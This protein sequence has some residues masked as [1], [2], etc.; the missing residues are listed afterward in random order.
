ML[1]NIGGALANALI[2]LAGCLPN[3]TVDADLGVLRAGLSEFDRGGTKDCA[4][5]TCPA[6]ADL[7]FATQFAKGNT[8][9]H[10]LLT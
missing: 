7:A 6:L 3:I 8:S 2:N 4:S 10:V 9:I 1:N 5:L